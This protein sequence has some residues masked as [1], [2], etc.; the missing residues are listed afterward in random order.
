VVPHRGQPRRHFDQERL[1]ELSASIK[2]R[3]LIEPII[4]RRH[5][6]LADRYEI[7]AGERRW[8]A[9]QLAGFSEIQV[10]VKELNSDEAFALA[11]IEN[12]Q[13][14]DLN[15]IELAEAYH[16]LI[17]EHDYTHDNIA[18]L[19]HKN[20]ATI[21]NTLRLLKLPERVREMILDGRLTEGHGRTLMG[22]DTD[23]DME[24]AAET[25]NREKLSVR[26]TEALVQSLK[27][28]P[29]PETP[30]KPA[31]EPRP[32][33][34]ISPNLRDLEE[35]LQRHLGTD[36]RVR[37]KSNNKGSIVIAYNNLD[38][39]DRILHQIRG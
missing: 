12:I 14:E 1:E 11:L 2:E 10:I 27:A 36:V 15:P 7:I 21:S 17:Q 25:V 13:R 32:A 39:L 18:E 37:N 20:R 9:C 16:R 6:T 24:R 38:E 29:P 28:P 30:E 31:R 23:E 19:V 33:P 4:V 22:L 5:P 35:T 26:Q 8:R 3:G 34:P